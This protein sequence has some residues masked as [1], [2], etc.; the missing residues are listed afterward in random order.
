MLFEKRKVLL[1]CLVLASLVTAAVA[2]SAGEPA[3]SNADLMKKLTSESVDEILSGVPDDFDSHDVVLVPYALDE[4]YE[5]IDNVFTRILTAKG[6]RV[7]AGLE[8][9]AAKQK[10]VDAGFVIEY[11]AT[12]FNLVYPKIYRSYLIGGK[13]VRR[14]ADVRLVAKVVDPA[15]DSVVWVGEAGRSHEDQFSYSELPAVEAG[16]FA[17]TKPPRKTTNWGKIAEPVVVSGIIVG[18]VYLF[19]SNQTD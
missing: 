16:V 2:A 18:L 7:H 10:R 3:I 4:R 11:Q 8:G 1:L 9:N 19:F 12:N 13:R 14:T 17:F 5:F 6:F 15:D